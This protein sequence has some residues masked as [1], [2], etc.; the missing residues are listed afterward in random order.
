MKRILLI[1][2]IAI[3]ISGLVPR[4]AGGQQEEPDFVT[5]IETDTTEVVGQ[6]TTGYLLDLAPQ[7][8]LTLSRQWDLE[9]ND[10]ILVFSAWPCE[11][12][13]IGEGQI[14]DH[15]DMRSRASTDVNDPGVVHNI[16]TRIRSISLSGDFGENCT[17]DGQIVV[18]TVVD[19]EFSALENTTEE[20]ELLPVVTPEPT[21]GSFTAT[22]SPQ[23]S[24]LLGPNRFGTGRLEGTLS[25][26]GTETSFEAEGSMNCAWARH[27]A[28]EEF[29]AGLGL[30][31]AAEADALLARGPFRPDDVGRIYRRAA[32]CPESGELTAECEERIEALKLASMRAEGDFLLE[33][34]FSPLFVDD[35]HGINT[36]E[37][38]RN[39]VAIAT[40][41]GPDGSPVV[42][43]LL[44]VIEHRAISDLL[45]K[46]FLDAESLRVF[47]QF[48]CISLGTLM[49]SGPFGC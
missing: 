3:V 38:F 46:A 29:G 5:I 9:A 1:G 8:D 44:E 37:L 47:S 28:P 21:F 20:R 18:S 40:L 49:E 39:V 32:G 25:I 6:F 23:S 41:P 26:D 27:S 11:G 30:C 35:P 16:W 17:M 15:F 45:H 14:R 22:W 34:A 33:R 48:M 24:D 42:P 10:V 36:F 19:E 43:G 7:S 2:V 12:E 13:V 31:T 4:V